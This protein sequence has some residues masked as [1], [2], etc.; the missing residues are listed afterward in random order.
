MALSLPRVCVY[1]CAHSVMS[2][3]LVIPWTIARQAPLSMEFSHLEYWYKLPFP[4][5]RDLPDPVTESMSLAS[6][7]FAGKFFT[8]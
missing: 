7:A 2:D 4:S 3:S 1:V 6:L 8:S 5:P